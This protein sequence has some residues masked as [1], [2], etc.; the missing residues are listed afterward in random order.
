M[1]NL[2]RRAV[3]LLGDQV[4]AFRAAASF[5]ARHVSAGMN[6]N[7]RRCGIEVGL[8]HKHEVNDSPRCTIV[9][10]VSNVHRRSVVGQF[11][12][13]GRSARNARGGCQGQAMITSI[14]GGNHFSSN[15][16]D[17]T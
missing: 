2:G 4:R 10:S 9:M 11:E 12:S 13:Q 16:Q 8:E 3:N 17:S 14:A 6:S 1:N 5:A 15:G 7:S